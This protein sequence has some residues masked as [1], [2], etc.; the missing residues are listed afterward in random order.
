MKRTR[1]LPYFFDKLTGTFTGFIIALW[2]TKLVSQFFETRGIRNLWGI[3]ARKTL[4]T[5]QTYEVLQWISTAVVGYIVF[6][7][8]LKVIRTYVA[9]HLFALKI[10]A[11]RWVIKNGWHVKMEKLG[12]R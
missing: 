2:A 7:I 11:M 4:V 10:K 3:T 6:E 5:K 9:P 12:Y 8:V 1:L